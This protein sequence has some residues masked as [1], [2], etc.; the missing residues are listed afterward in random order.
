M[1]VS[2]SDLIKEL[3]IIYPNLL[4]KELLKIFDIFLNEIKLALKNNERVELRG[5]GIFHQ[6]LQKSRNSRNPKTGEK[7]F[8]SEKKS[9]NFKM[10]K[11]LFEFINE[12]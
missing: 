8:T 5:W 6:R 1:S 12:K 9:I 2:K 4:K 11:E 7:I 3:K 10:S